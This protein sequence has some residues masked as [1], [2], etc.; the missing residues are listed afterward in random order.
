MTAAFCPN[1]LKIRERSSFRSF[2][3]TMAFKKPNAPFSALPTL[4]TLAAA[5][6]PKV[7]YTALWISSRWSPRMLTTA[8]TADTAAMAGPTP[9]TRPPSSPAAGL[10]I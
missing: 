10:Q 5:A 7:L 6:G 9:V 1:V 4:P 2:T 8:I 3:W